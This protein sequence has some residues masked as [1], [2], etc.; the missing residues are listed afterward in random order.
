MRQSTGVIFA[1]INAV[2][3]TVIG[4]VFINIGVNTRR[5]TDQSRKVS[6]TFILLGVISI[7]FGW[8]WR[9]LVVKYPFLETVQG[10]VAT[11]ML[12]LLFLRWKNA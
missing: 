10:I 4:L 6:N 1:T 5:D 7:L 12:L 8:G 11:V 9:W 2:I 3:F